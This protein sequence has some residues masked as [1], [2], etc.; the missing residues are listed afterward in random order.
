VGWLPILN[1]LYPKS[2]QPMGVNWGL[3][4]PVEGKK[5]ERKQKRVDRARI[6]IEYA[7]RELGRVT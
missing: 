2:K 5:S 4:P 1:N 6:A 7:A 3:V